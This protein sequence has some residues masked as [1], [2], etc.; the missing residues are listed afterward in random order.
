MG[1]SDFSGCYHWQELAKMI[2]EQ[3]LEKITHLLK[4]KYTLNMACALLK[5]DL[6][7]IKNNASEAQLQELAN[8]HFIKKNNFQEDFTPL[9]E[10]L[11]FANQNLHVIY[12]IYEQRDRTIR[13]HTAI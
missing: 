8:H 6:T 7:W 13:S 12:T 4:Q 2:I 10:Y 5:I 9:A 3:A 1:K 11:Q